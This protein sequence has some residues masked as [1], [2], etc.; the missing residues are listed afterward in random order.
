MASDQ[1]RCDP[2]LDPAASELATE[3]MTALGDS[4]W[5]DY[6]LACR[7]AVRRRVLLIR[8]MVSETD[9]VMPV[10]ATALS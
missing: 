6:I 7:P 3:S 1:D 4:I 5:R 10:V 8:S 9:P 2:S